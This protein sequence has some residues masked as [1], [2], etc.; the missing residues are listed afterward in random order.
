MKTALVFDTDVVKDV[1]VE[2][3]MLYEWIL[4]MCKFAQSENFGLLDGSWWISMNEKTRKQLF[5]FWNRKDMQKL[6]AKLESKEYIKVGANTERVAAQT[7]STQ[8][9]ILPKPKKEEAILPNKDIYT[10]TKMVDGVESKVTE[11]E[12]VAVSSFLNEFKEVNR[13]Y[14]TFFGIPHYRKAVKRLFKVYPHTDHLFLLVRNLKHT[15]QMK[16]APII[17][18]PLE[19]E[20]KAPMLEAFIQKEGAKNTNS[21]EF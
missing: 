10:F 19:F 20:R 13:N 12:E 4:Q 11:Q 18:T 7:L 21:L 2:A 15:N 14:K 16:F 1:G 9:E 17:T 5:P 8:I 3:A 6:I